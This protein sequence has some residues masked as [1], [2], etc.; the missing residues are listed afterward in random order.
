MCNAL[1]QSA[2]PSLQ[3]A[4]SLGQFYGHVDVIAQDHASNLMTG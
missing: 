1:F 4:E 2:K 3:W